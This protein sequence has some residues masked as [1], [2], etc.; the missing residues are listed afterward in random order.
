MTISILTHA[1]RKTKNK[2]IE[3]VIE[4]PFC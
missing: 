3:I 2:L 4:N 1:P